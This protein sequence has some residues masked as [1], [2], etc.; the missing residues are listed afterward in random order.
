MC[1]GW[2][3]QGGPVKSLASHERKAVLVARHQF[4]GMRV[5]MDNQVR[6]ILKTF[7]LVIARVALVRSGGLIDC[8]LYGPRLR[9]AL[10]GLR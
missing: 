7:G 6:G 1:P 10:L 9:S 4:V 8:Q 5:Q 3:V 2:L